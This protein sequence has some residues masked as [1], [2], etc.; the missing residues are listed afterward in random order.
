MTFVPALDADDVSAG[1]LDATSE[2]ASSAKYF[3]TRSGRDKKN[4]L[5]AGFQRN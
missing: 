2:T 4:L 3:K 5:D 1:G